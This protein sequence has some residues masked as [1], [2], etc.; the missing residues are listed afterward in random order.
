MSLHTTCGYDLAEVRKSLREAIGR[1]DRRAAN[2]WA[3]ELVVTPGAIGSLW[4]S[5][6][7]ACEASTEGNPTLPILFGQTWATLVQKAQACATDWAQF[8]NDESVRRAVAELTCRL[9]EYPRQSMP[10]LPAKEVALYDV[11][12]VL[13]KAMPASA[14]SSV[15]LSIWSRNHD[16]MELR[17]L[18]GHWIDA[19]QTGELRLALSILVWSLLPSTKLKCGARGPKQVP[20]TAKGSPMWFWFSLGSS[21]LKA[22][23]AHPGW[24]TFH[25][26]T[27]EAMS[28]HY[29]RWSPTER[30]KILA[31]WTLNLRACLS[32]RETWSIK[33][34]PLTTEEIDLPYK[35]IATEL[36]GKHSGLIQ[37]ASTTSKTL[38]SKE[39][40]TP[41]DEKA[42]KELKLSQKMKD[43]DDTVLAMLG[44]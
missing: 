25:D 17:Q 32:S 40:Q 20:A 27:V 1:R 15:V 6:W 44:V 38:G 22:A 21:F 26:M 39:A 35:E 42:L 7:L 43:A 5:Y 33:A 29:R 19:I 12:T 24:L 36:A 9:L 10:S 2:R 13:E 16:S 8:R 4:A 3:A 31:F 37:Q 30:L 34:V 11:S 23:N 14:D 41:K 28:D 18:A